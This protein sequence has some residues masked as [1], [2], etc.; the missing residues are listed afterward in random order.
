MKLYTGNIVVTWSLNLWRTLNLWCTTSCKLIEKWAK[1][2]P[3]GMCGLVTLLLCSIVKLW[4][5]T[6]YNVHFQLLK[7]A[8]YTKWTCQQLYSVHALSLCMLH[9]KP[10][11][12]PASAIAHNNYSH[13]ISPFLNIAQWEEHLAGL[14]RY[15]VWA[16]DECR[17]AQVEALAVWEETEERG[18]GVW[19]GA[20]QTRR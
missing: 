15:R 20:R 19:G 5:V 2:V 4:P 7:Y 10:F 3:E 6:Q 8:I 13:L 14:E 11:A 17:V 12:F 16:W 9:N 18:V 1:V